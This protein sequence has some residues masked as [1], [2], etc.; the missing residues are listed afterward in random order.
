MTL[1]LT[2]RCEVFKVAEIDLLEIMP[3]SSNFRANFYLSKVSG[4]GQTS[5]SP[6]FSRLS[7]L[8]ASAL[9]Q[10]AWRT[11]KGN[12]PITRKTNY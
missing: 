11:E 4:N 5:A 9:G 2:S 12:L 6:K 1:P 3:V 10:L 7:E 8:Q